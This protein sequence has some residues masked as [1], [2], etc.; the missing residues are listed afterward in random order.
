MSKPKKRGPKPIPTHCHKCG[1]RCP[2]ARLARVHCHKK[3]AA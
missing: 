1:K 2:S 3:E